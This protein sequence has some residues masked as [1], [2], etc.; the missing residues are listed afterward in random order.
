[1]IAA[2]NAHVGI[3]LGGHFLRVAYL[4]G[5]G[6]VSSGELSK[7]VDLIIRGG[8]LLVNSRRSIHGIRVGVREHVVLSGDCDLELGDGDSVD[9]G[10]LGEGDLGRRGHDELRVAAVHGNAFLVNVD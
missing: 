1:M 3:E 8:S 6:C 7:D 9:L 2:A 4:Q 5:H 10:R